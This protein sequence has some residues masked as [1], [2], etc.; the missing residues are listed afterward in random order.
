MVGRGCEK[1]E[2]KR[3]FALTKCENIEFMKVRIDSG[4]IG[5]VRV[6][7]LT[8]CTYEVRKVWVYEG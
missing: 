6:F 8:R 4:N 2:V 7:A 5:M 1:V 3:V